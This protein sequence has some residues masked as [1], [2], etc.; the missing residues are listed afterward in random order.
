MDAPPTCRSAE[1]PLSHPLAHYA[2][3][4]PTW[5]ISDHYAAPH[6]QVLEFP[7]GMDE[8]VSRPPG[9]L[10]RAGIE[11]ANEVHAQLVNERLSAPYLSIYPG[12]EIQ[13]SAWSYSVFCLDW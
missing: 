7:L 4:A 2:S 3:V 13:H 11:N 10:G 6:G 12:I 1:R 9:C 8:N 5:C